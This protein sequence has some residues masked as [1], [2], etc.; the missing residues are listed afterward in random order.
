MATVPSLL[1]NRTQGRPVPSSAHAA[2]GATV[3]REAGRMGIRYYAYAFDA[4]LAQ[5]AA[6]DP[7]SIQIGRAHV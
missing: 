1:H 3:R 6:D 5:Q 7:Y 2:V 4:D